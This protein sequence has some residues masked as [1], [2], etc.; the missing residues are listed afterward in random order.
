VE[1][2]VAKDPPKRGTEEEL[3]WVRRIPDPDERDASDFTPITNFADMGPAL[4]EIR[5]TVRDIK[6]KVD[7]LV[8]HNASHEARIK[9]SEARLRRVEDKAAEIAEKPQ[10]HDCAQTE[11]IREIKEEAHRFRKSSEDTTQRVIVAE[12]KVGALA[13]E[14][15]TNQG[16]T[17]SG[18]RWLIGI[19]VT[20][21]I[22][23]GGA[24]LGWVITLVT[25]RSDVAHLA[26]EQQE[27]Q[28]RLS[29]VQVTT[30]KA[31]VRVEAAAKRIE[32]VAQE[33]EDEPAAFIALDDVWC[34]LSSPEREKLRR[35]LPSDRLPARRC[36]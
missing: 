25:V 24:A 21:V 30:T 10:S 11:T 14:M 34:N 16:D 36:P 3:K 2:A 13:K 12:T 28:E 5:H 35:A 6:P 18:R 7:K 31:G 32:T 8:E 23:I 29:T 26:T 17:K 15:E 9:A 27:I 20:L 22:V 1:A 33:T 19:I 4:S